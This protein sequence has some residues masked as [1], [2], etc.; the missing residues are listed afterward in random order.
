MKEKTKLTQS[1]F[2]KIVAFFV[3]VISIVTLG[4]SILAVVIMV[5]EDIYIKTKE[6]FVEQYSHNLASSDSLNILYNYLNN[7]E[8]SALAVADIKNIGFELLDEKGVK[9][10]GN[11]DGAP[12]RSSYEFYYDYDEI[13]HPKLETGSSYT[14]KFYINKTFSV[15]DDYYLLNTAIDIFYSLRYTVYVIGIVCVIL[16]VASFSFLMCAAGQ[17]KGQREITETNLTRIPFDILTFMLVIM[18]RVIFMLG[19]Y[20]RNNFFLI[21]VG[22]IFIIIGTL[23]CM[24]FA[25]RVKLGVLWKN[26]IVAFILKFIYRCARKVLRGILWFGKN[27]TLLWKVIFFVV[28]IVLIQLISMLLCYWEMDNY[29]ILWA[30]ETWLFLHIIFYITYILV[31]LQKGA[32]VFANGDLSYKVDTSKMF[33]EFKKHGDNLNRIA[34]GMNQAVEERMKSERLKTE[35]IT[36]VS[37]DIKTPLTSIINYSDLISKEETD[38]PAITEYAEVLFRQSERLKKL[39]DDLMEASKAVTGN[40][41]VQLVPCEVGVL[42]TQTVGEYE[43]RMQDGDLELI[44]KQPDEVIRILADGRLLWRV[45]D[46]LMNNIC[47]YAQNN[48][49][50]YLSVEEKDGK[51]LISFKNISKYSLDISMEELMER[52]VRGDK[53]RNTEGNGLGLSIARNLVELQ[54]GTF[55]LTIDGDLFKVVIGFPLLKTEE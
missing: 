33:G 17:R 20:Y 40:I 15:T 16:V 39:I 43:Q 19:Y 18:V 55:E 41:E 46:N 27:I 48:T 9:I 11:Y 38:N 2:A 14:V 35:L 6:Q 32:D 3:L 26:T 31:K 23:Y 5:E 1:L 50:V 49:R 29:L 10:F 53:S 42:L 8:S 36:N 21:L 24:S 47:K 52:F 25:I 13:G 30:L 34:T 37:H 51:A 7:G 22:I 45:F 12:S 4:A 28:V 44:T 54:N